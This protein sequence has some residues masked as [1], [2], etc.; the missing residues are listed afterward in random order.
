MKSFI[1]N[2]SL[3]L[4]LALLAFIFYLHFYYLPGKNIS[5]SGYDKLVNM[6]D[7]KYERVIEEQCIRKMIDDAE[8]DGK[9]TQGEFNQIKYMYEEILEAERLREEHRKGIENARSRAAGM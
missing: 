7:H 6:I 9:V 4:T 3:V 1:E 8:N 5:E 2:L